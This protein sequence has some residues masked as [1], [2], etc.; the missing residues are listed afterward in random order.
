MASDRASWV[1]SP[2]LL[3]RFLLALPVEESTITTRNRKLRIVNF[4]CNFLLKF[5]KKSY[6]FLKILLFANTYFITITIKIK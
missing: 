3:R 6:F 5:K 2:L 1:A 4:F